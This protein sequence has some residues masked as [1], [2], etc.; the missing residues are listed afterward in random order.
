MFQETAQISAF[1]TPPRPTT[2]PLSLSLPVSPVSPTTMFWNPPVATQSTQT[3]F[4]SG[5][6]TDL[7][8]ML[9]N[10]F[11]AAVQPSSGQATYLLYGDQLLPLQTMPAMPQLFSHMPQFAPLAS[12]TFVAPTRTEK[13]DTGETVYLTPETNNGSPIF[14]DVD[15]RMVFMAATPPE[16][17]EGTDT[18]P[19]TTE[20]E[21]TIG[22]AVADACRPSA[23][24]NIDSEHLSDISCDIS[25]DKA[26]KRATNKRKGRKREG[27]AKLPPVPGLRK[28]LCTV[29]GTKFLTSGVCVFAD[30]EFEY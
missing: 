20:P 17:R 22:T 25:E 16:E 30:H 13:R 14:S 2:M 8:S 23:L 12:E 3:L 29:C 28:Y 27:S 18:E 10:Y 19:A 4:L 24:L 1:G 11:P 5:G 9:V 7:A 15:P 6:T 26:K 21:P